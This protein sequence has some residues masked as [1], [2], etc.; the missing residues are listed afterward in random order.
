MSRFHLLQTSITARPN[1]VTVFDPVAA[2]D[3]EVNP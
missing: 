1:G 2:G 3:P